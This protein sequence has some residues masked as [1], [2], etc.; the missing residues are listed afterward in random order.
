MLKKNQ[1]FRGWIFTSP[2]GWCPTAGPPLAARGT[3]D[4]GQTPEMDLSK[5]L[6]FF[7]DKLFVKI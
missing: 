3:M 6:G 7:L 2:G 4:Q 1:T 5:H